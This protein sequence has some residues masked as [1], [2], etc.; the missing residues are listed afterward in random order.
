MSA[1]ILIERLKF[2]RIANAN[3]LVIAMKNRLRFSDLFWGVLKG[4]A[5][6]ALLLCLLAGR[7]TASPS[8]GQ[9]V[10]ERKVSL[11]VEDQSIKVALSQLAKQTSIRFIYSQQLVRA[12]RRVTLRVRETPLATVLD[13]LLAPLKLEYEVNDNRVVLH[14]PAQPAG[15][16]NEPNTGAAN[17][18]DPNALAPPVSGRVTDGSG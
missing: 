7:A 10:L 13:E 8:L 9:A 12:E 6:S 17:A 15:G 18:N 4:L 2:N 3:F 11:Q 16:P 5:L 1:Q 14:V